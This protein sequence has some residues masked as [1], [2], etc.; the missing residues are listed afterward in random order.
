MAVISA[1]QHCS[2]LLTV[3][4]FACTSSLGCNA[5]NLASYLVS[6]SLTNWCIQSNWTFNYKWQ[7]L[8]NISMVW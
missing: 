5:H 6:L 2:K 8:I 7:V 1:I 4:Q 3:C